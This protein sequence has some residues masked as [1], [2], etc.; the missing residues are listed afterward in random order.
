[1]LAQRCWTVYGVPAQLLG[2]NGKSVKTKN[3]R[4]AACTNENGKMVKTTQFSKRRVKR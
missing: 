2:E 3:A 1:M 4:H